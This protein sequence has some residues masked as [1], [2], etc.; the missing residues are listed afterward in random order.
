MASVFMKVDSKKS[1]YNIYTGNTQQTLK[2]IIE[3]YFFDIQHMINNGKKLNNLLA[4]MSNTLNLL[5][6]APTCVSGIH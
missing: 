5:C 1:L 2:K 3:G 4:N 6:Q